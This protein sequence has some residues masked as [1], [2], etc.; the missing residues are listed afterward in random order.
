MS[1][2]EAPTSPIDTDLDSQ[3]LLSSRLDELV[4]S[5][6]LTVGQGHE[7][8]LDK[9]G[10]PIVSDVNP[11]TKVKENPE[12]QRLDNIIQFLESPVAP[13]SVDWTSARKALC[14]LRDQ[15][16]PREGDADIIA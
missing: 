6:A 4:C 10:L 13:Q 1:S 3:N 5:G 9:D 7:L 12:Q 15:G 11:K 16:V 2:S 14:Q 8:T